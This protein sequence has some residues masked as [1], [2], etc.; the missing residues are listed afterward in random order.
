MFHYSEQIA[1][2]SKRKRK[3]AN[4]DTEQRAAKKRAKE[5]ASANIDDAY[6]DVDEDGSR[7]L[8][9][10]EIRN[11][12]RAY[13]RYGSLDERY[14]EIVGDAGLTDRNAQFIK[15]TIM[16]MIRLGKFEIEATQAKQEDDSKP[17]KKEKKAILFDFKGARKLNA[18]TIVQRPEDLKVLRRAIQ[19]FSDV[20]KFRIPDVKPVHGWSCPWGAREDGMLCVGINK[21]GYGAWVAI[22]DDPDLNMKDKL[23]LEEH[24]VEK[25][26]ARMNGNVK[27]P[28]AVHLVRRAEYL[29]GVLRDRI[30]HE[31]SEISSKRSPDAL[32][33]PR[34]NGTHVAIRSGKASASASPAPRVKKGK[35]KV[36]G[37]LEHSP[38]SESTPKVAGKKKHYVDET[39]KRVKKKLKVPVVVEEGM[40]AIEAAKVASYLHSISHDMY[41]SA[42]SNH[43]ENYAPFAKPS[44][45]CEHRKILNINQF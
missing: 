34:K 28:G 17:G 4:G 22:R 2:N 6:D 41:M 24:R 16:E 26:E 14:N 13:T 25:K 32:P 27:S 38:R 45:N 12:Y 18:E 40:D 3:A 21:H 23:F 20:S 9:E 35:M 1:Q 30:A 10:R 36:N 19:A 33:K 8:N 15:D 44:M 11:L 31:L 5:L 42:N 37:K 7:P 29:L 39:E 43:S